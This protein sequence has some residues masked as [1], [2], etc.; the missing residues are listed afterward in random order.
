MRHPAVYT[1]FI[2]VILF[3]ACGRRPH[4][5]MDEDKMADVLYDLDL[6][7]TISSGDPN[8]RTE[9]QKEA[10]KNGILKK[11]EITQAEL[12]SSLLWYSD[13]IEIY[14]KINDSVASRLRNT[15]KAILD[16]RTAS[17]S[18][19]NLSNY[20]IPP[21]FYLNEY[22]PTMSLSIDSLRIKTIDLPKFRLKF[23]VQG[24]SP[25]VKAE[26]AV[27]FIY[28]DTLVKRIIPMVRNTRYTFDKPHLADSLLKS[29]AGYVHVRCKAEGIPLP[30]VLIYNLSYTDSLV[31][32]TPE[33]PQGGRPGV[34][35]APSPTGNR[36][37]TPERIRDEGPAKLKPDAKMLKKAPRI[38]KEEIEQNP[39]MHSSQAA[40][41]PAVQK[42]NKRK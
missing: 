27:F 34:S 42:G 7:R 22:A 10:L 21:Y 19:G 12:D 14:N 3:A 6:A 1:I 35:P 24:L 41:K 5:V 15:N 20:L 39:L 17:Y 40:P 23:D 18:S 30:D 37:A 36:N 33:Q 32:K 29:I 38:S 26:A 25:L 4:Y 11:H 13:N 2:V 9:A 8:F 31:R 16:K 28:K